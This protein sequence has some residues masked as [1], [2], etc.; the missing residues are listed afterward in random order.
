VIWRWLADATALLH[1][2]WVLAVVLGPAWAWRRPLR[3]LAH[4]VF[5]WVSAAVGLSGFYCPLTVAETSL[6]A[7]YDPAGAYAEGFVADHLNRLASCQVRDADVVRW[8]LGWALLWTAVYA[9]LAWRDR[10]RVRS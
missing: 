4:G 8:T 10:R 7:H 9:V 2:A 5:L 1:G 3:R 6:R